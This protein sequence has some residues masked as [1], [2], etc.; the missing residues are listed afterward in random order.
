MYKLIFPW[1]SKFIH[2][3]I[4]THLIFEIISIIFGDFTSFFGQLTNA[5][6]EE[7]WRFWLDKFIDA[8]SDLTNCFKMHIRQMMLKANKPH[9][10]EFPSLIYIDEILYFFCS[11]WSSV[12]VLQ[13]HLPNS[14]TSGTISCTFYTSRSLY[15]EWNKS[16]SVFQQHFFLIQLRKECSVSNA[17]FR[18]PSYSLLFREVISAGLSTIIVHLKA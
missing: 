3:K 17:T 14:E 5:L 13:N 8:F 11:M 2:E 15:S 1:N 10:E 4:S 6:A 9:E 7:T 12:V 16:F 18:P